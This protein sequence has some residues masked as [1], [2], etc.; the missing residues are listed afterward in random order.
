[1]ALS[2]PMTQSVCDRVVEE[3]A[4]VLVEVDVEHRRLDRV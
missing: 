3:L 2:T 4:G 1:M